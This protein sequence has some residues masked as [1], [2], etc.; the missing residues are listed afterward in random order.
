MY[1]SVKQ[2]THV[3]V[4]GRLFFYIISTEILILVQADYS[5]FSTPYPS[6]G[7]KGHNM[8][9]KLEPQAEGPFWIKRVHVNISV[10]IKISLLVSH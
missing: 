7:A 3:N 1:L 9:M 5:Q 8:P 6:L 2:D 4:S 10:T